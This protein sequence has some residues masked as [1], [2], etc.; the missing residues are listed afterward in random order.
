MLGRTCLFSGGGVD[1]SHELTSEKF[2]QEIS[3]KTKAI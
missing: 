3:K 1:I 2:W